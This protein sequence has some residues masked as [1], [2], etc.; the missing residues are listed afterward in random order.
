MEV[1]RIV[2]IIRTNKFDFEIANMMADLL[3]RMKV[4]RVVIEDGLYELDQEDI[5][6]AA[7]VALNYFG[8]SEQNL[9]LPPNLDGDII[10]KSVSK[11]D[12]YL[13]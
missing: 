10:K 8:V 11:L 9:A 1:E 5:A 6:A 12:E 2:S 7:K 13:H 4:D 3:N